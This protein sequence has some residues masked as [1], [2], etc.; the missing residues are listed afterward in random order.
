MDIKGVFRNV[1]PFVGRTDEAKARQKTD[2]NNDRE[3]NGQ[4]A[5]GGEDQRRRQLTDE[6]IANA[7]KYL[8]GLAGVKDNNLTVRAETKDGITVVYVQDRDGKVVR[9]I[10][11]S[12]LSLLAGAPQKKTGHLLNKAM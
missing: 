10:P 9:R 3:G 4:A 7:I 5:T 1:I 2:A 12:E 11:E 6:E 8:E